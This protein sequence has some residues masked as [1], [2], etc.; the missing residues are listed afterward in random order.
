MVR[1]TGVRKLPVSSRTVIVSAPQTECGAGVVENSP[2]PAP[3]GPN[4]KWSPRSTHERQFDTVS[5]KLSNES[6]TSV[7][8]QRLG[9]GLLVQ[10]LA[11]HELSPS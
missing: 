8:T 6:E 10:Q 4:R 9:S 11:H 7:R 2:G 5:A 3:A 1:E